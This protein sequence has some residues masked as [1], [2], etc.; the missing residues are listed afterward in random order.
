MYENIHQYFWSRFST[1]QI[2]R[3]F[4]VRLVVRTRAGEEEVAEQFRELVHLGEQAGVGCLVGPFLGEPC[5]LRPPTIVVYNEKL[6]GWVY[7]IRKKVVQREFK[8]LE[9][10]RTKE[11]FPYPVDI[12]L[13][14]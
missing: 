5:K 13:P 14:V 10:N 9:K 2:S 1:L 6:L 11:Y 3:E 8:F 4:E 12:S 7:F